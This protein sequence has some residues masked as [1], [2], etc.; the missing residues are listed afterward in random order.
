MSRYD[1][2]TALLVVDV[3]ND[4]AHP[5]GNL[6]VP[7]GDAIIERINEE[8][9]AARRA[10]STVVYTQD[11]HPEATPH[12]AKDGGSWPVHC[13]DGTWGAELHPDL[14]SPRE[15]DPVIRKGTGGEDGYSAFSV[16]DPE[17]GDSDATELDRILRDRGVRRTV[18]LGLAQ[19]VCV[20]DTT[21]DA[22]RLGYETELVADATRPV[23]LQPGDGDR[24]LEAAREAGAV[25]R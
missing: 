4:F 9:E 10:G 3:Q 23:D 15:D 17:S 24:A 2:T 1:E 20:K 22:R 7:G 6:Y 11:A 16:R 5:E 14:T 8:I 19:D 18:V 21:L 13:V 12:F 25:V